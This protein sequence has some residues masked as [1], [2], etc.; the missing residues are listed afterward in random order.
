MK[1]DSGHIEPYRIPIRAEE[2]G[3]TGSERHGRLVRLTS[4]TGLSA[5]GDAAPLPGFSNETVADVDRAWSTWIASCPLEELMQDLPPD[6]PPSLRFAIDQA[7]LGL[8]TAA[9]GSP[10]PI[11]LSGQYRKEVHVGAL[12]D[13]STDD[14]VEQAGRLANLGYMSI[15]IKV[16]KWN[17]IA[18]ADAV[19]ATRLTVANDTQITLDANRAWGFDEASEFLKRIEDCD[20]TYVEEPLRN[21]AHLDRLAASVNVGIALDESILEF[22]PSEL[23]QWAFASHIVVK[24]TLVGGL[25]R[26]IEFA[27]AAAALGIRAVASACFESGIGILGVLSLAFSENF[28]AVAGV[29]TYRRLRGDVLQPRLLLPPRVDINILNRVYDGPS[30]QE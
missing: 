26:G 23:N 4:D 6:M 19:R 29:D 17:S 30:R 13:C 7:R 12:L 24:P 25:T 15:K 20:I 14:A 1:C 5:W 22:S 8:E 3:L 16:G 21:P 2:G 9:R 27:E 18:A 28:D 10:H 11:L